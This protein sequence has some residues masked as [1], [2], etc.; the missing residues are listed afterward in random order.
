LTIVSASACSGCGVCVSTNGLLVPFTPIAPSSGIIVLGA[1]TCSTLRCGVSNSASG[2]YS[3]S[4]G[5]NY[6]TSHA[7]AGFIGGGTCNNV[8][9]VTSGCLSYGAVVVGGVGNNTTGG[10]W[11]LATCTFTVAPTICNAGLYSFIGGG[12]Q[13]KVS[14]CFSTIGGGCQNTLSGFLSTISG[15]VCHTISGA[16]STISGGYKNTASGNRSVISGGGTNTA[17][18]QYSNISGGK[19]NTSSAYT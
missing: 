15:G 6:N 7:I 3:A 2:N 9:N 17:S 18:A 4:V 19:G 5:V 10:T 11:D 8:C 16:Y 12:F 1:G 13:N 14:G